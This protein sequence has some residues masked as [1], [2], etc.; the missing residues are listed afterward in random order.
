MACTIS[1]G[2]IRHS[3]N[4]VNIRSIPYIFLVKAR[5]Q[6]ETG[7]KPSP[8]KER[9]SFWMVVILVPLCFLAGGELLLR[10]VDYG[11]N[12]DL[13]VRKTVLGKE[14]YTLNR[15]VARRYFSQKGIA[16]PEA[17][18]DVFEVQKRPNT[19]RI[20]MLGE[21]TMA[22]YPFDYNAT[23]PRLLQDRLSRLLPEYNIEVVNVGLAA[24]NSY[25]VLD[26]IK[27][28]V[29]YQP[30]A[31]VVYLGHNEFYGA[32]GIG[33]T[34]YLGQWR[35]LVNAYIQMRSFRIFLMVRD[36]I[37]AL[38][39]VF[40]KVP[41]PREST[42]M[43]AMVREKI[44]PY[45]SK[46]YRIARGIFEENLQSIV[47]VAI[48][49]G[50]PIVLSTLASNIRNQE[51]LQATF[52][53]HT[54]GEVKVQW[55]RMYESGIAEEKQGHF[56]LAMDNL[57]EAI[58]SDS[59]NADAHFQFAKCLD[60]LGSYAEAKTEYEKA[61]DYDGL[62]FRASTDFNNLIRALCNQ[63]DVSVA[64]AEKAFEQ[65]SPHR[66]VGSNLMLEHLHPN[67]QGYFLLAKTF[68][69]TIVDNNVV[70]PQGAWHWDRNLTDDQFVDS[71]GVTE[72]D[73]EAANYRISQLTNGWPFQHVSSAEGDYVPKNKVQELAVQ[74]VRK[75]IAWSQARY[76]L[77]NWY[78]KQ[79][80]YDKALREYYAV[81]KV[82]PY[83]YYPFMMMG[84]MYRL[85]GKDSAAE[86][87]YGKALAVQQSPFVHVRLG[88]MYFEQRK[89]EQ[90]IHEF[91]ETIASE[92]TENMDVHARSTARY[93][94]GAAYGKS[95]DIQ[96]AKMYL[97][98]AVQIDP[99]NGDA[100][101]MLSQIQ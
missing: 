75:K 55:R 74:Y 68:F 64:D 28:L 69:Q 5:N 41:T 7:E 54:S 49:H 6:V 71:S 86:D 45:N 98:L 61:R 99:Q 40:T 21:S 27:E 89:T 77:A 22:G 59:M 1:D 57:R 16:I 3:K 35:W 97:Q 31:F 30:D 42:L 100:K 81:S 33:S 60:T 96:K 26:F 20:F 37:V 19:K 88:M 52:G 14:Y 84:D 11:G 92:G 24:V 38:R 29:H 72:F 18:D 93:F 78:T 56:Q 65:Q 67:F 53:E 43:E 36:G 70:A 17:Y 23:A 47:E 101:K 48:H 76:D 90:S 32:M 34:E 9:Q 46:E 85:Q 83:Y 15:E 58:H 63:Q 4:I 95:G 91:E 66:L 94:L 2:N 51:P 44:I 25:T 13:V 12:L 10:W 82:I 39:N 79:G 8:P 80:K 73:L 62:R 87:Q 50:V